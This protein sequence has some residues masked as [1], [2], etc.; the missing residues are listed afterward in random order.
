MET[1][2]LVWDHIIILYI[3]KKEGPTQAKS[4][5]GKVQPP[6][7]R[8]HECLA[9]KLKCRR[10]EVK[11]KDLNVARY[12]FKVTLSALHCPGGLHKDPE[13]LAETNKTKQKPLTLWSGK[14][15][16]NDISTLSKWQPSLPLDKEL[17]SKHCLLDYFCR[18]C[19]L[20][21]CTKESKGE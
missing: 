12:G 18:L 3:W 13:S 17:T 19:H 1:Q 21:G 16:S 10:I 9:P 8:D 2:G 15:V 6:G 7:R 14:S 11:Q 20:Q 4:M 5:V